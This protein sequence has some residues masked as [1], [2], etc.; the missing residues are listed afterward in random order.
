MMYTIEELSLITGLTT[1]TLRN[2]LKSDILQGSK[3]S[4]LW[5]FTEEQ[6]LNFIHHPSVWPSIKAKHCA[7]VYDFLARQD[8]SKNEMCVLLDRTLGENEAKELADFFCNTTNRLSHIRFA[9]SYKCGIARYI[10]KG[11]EDDMN[12]VMKAFYCR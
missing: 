6:I 5:E 9:F 12:Q 2:Y 10:L 1:R 8:S 3:E 11:Q 7:I 4:G